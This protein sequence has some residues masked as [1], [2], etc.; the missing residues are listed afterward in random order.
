MKINKRKYTMSRKAKEQRANAPRKVSAVAEKDWTT[1]HISR[2]NE[3]WAKEK[4]GT[5]N[6]ALDYARE[7]NNI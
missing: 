4:F 6:A 1:A 7:L 5:A 2:E 3:R